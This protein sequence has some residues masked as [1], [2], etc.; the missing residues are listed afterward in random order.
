MEIFLIAV[1]LAM[2]SAALS[3]ASGARHKSIGLGGTVKIGAV[4]AFF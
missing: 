4:F 2:D 3:V 1:A